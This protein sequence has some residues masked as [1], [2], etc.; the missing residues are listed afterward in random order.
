MRSTQARK[1][2]GVS[3]PG[4]VAGH[5]VCCMAVVSGMKGYG[6]PA[7]RFSALHLNLLTAR[8]LDMR[9][10]AALTCMQELDSNSMGLDSP[11]CRAGCALAAS[12]GPPSRRQWRG[13]RHTRC[14][15][16][17]AQTNPSS[18]EPA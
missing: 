7:V 13:P 18:A 4:A 17:M 5:K 14:A 3:K 12:P 1:S 15:G 10:N 11:L 6:G 9:R 8:K 16:W 2:A